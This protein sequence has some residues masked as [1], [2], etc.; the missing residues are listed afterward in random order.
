VSRDSEAA[1][2]V[3]ADARRQTLRSSA[4]LMCGDWHAA[5]DIVQDVLARVFSVW[6]RVSA[7]GDPT[8]YA[9]RAVVNRCLDYR[10]RPARRELSHE[11]LPLDLP[12]RDAIE[13]AGLRHDLIA[14]LREVPVGQR[15]VLVLRFW[16]DLSVEQTA[17]LLATSTGNVKSQT[18]RGLVALRAALA[19]RGLSDVLQLA[20]EPT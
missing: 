1:F 10:R 6:D 3:W 18:S 2:R 12:E 13:Q 19:R 8:A 20:E 11:L 4:F 17:A 5:E 14:A 15:A 7:S 9:R 16:E